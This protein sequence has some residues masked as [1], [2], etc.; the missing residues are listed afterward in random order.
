MAE[1]ISKDVKGD[2][3]KL[4][5]LFATGFAI[6]FLAF[7]SSLYFSGYL[8][9]RRICSHYFPAGEGIFEFLG[10]IKGTF[11]NTHY[12]LG[13]FLSCPFLRWFHTDFF[14]YR[15]SHSL[16]WGILAL[17][18]FYF[19]KALTNNPRLSL[20]ATVVTFLLPPFLE[21]PPVPEYSNPLGAAF[22]FLICIFFFI[23]KRNLFLNL[24]YVIIALLG[25][26]LSEL[27]RLYSLPLFALLYFVYSERR[28][29]NT[30]WLFSLAFL[31]LLSFFIHA[32]LVHKSIIYSFKGVK[33]VV[34]SFIYYVHFI[35]GCY[36]FSFGYLGMLFLTSSFIR[37]LSLRKH[38]IFYIFF[39]LSLLMVLSLPLYS[40]SEFFLDFFFVTPSVPW[41]FFLLGFALLLSGGYSAFKSKEKW[42]V[43]SFFA[44]FSAS[45]I[46]LFVMGVFPRIRNDPSARHLLVVFPLFSLLLV[47]IGRD[48]IKESKCRLLALFIISLAVL[49]NIFP[50]IYVISKQHNLPSLTYDLHLYF[51]RE[52]K[53]TRESVC[54]Y[55]LNP[56]YYT[57]GPQEI[58]YPYKKNVRTFLLFVRPV[59][60]GKIDEKILEERSEECD[61]KIGIFWRFRPL[62]NPLY[63]L[64][65]FKFFEYMKTFSLPRVRDFQFNIAESSFMHSLSPLPLEYQL[66]KFP[67]L[68]AAETK[69]CSF[70]L[71]LNELL[72]RLIHSLPLCI[73]Y[74]YSF[75]IFELSP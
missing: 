24:L 75:Y 64:P 10:S 59:L 15:F 56:Q 28:E 35:Y 73:E 67:L 25:T 33:G 20:I 74:K 3:V 53:R 34:F 62:H 30:F 72:N 41:Q 18:V 71:F 70:P 14:L 6:G 49:R 11:F 61:R 8:L 12:K 42:E 45:G 13:V 43:F 55:Y 48:W 51:I 17:L 54:V 16:L 32:M 23:R 57:L 66:K 31:T 22:V 21:I 65:S 4:S 50:F 2:F 44:I 27:S 63:L 69:Y 60:D 58:G 37:F 26:F 1:S 47:K 46:L 36:L 40:Y 29:E 19:L 7:P 9:I 39:L 38:I 68:F 5:F 52:L